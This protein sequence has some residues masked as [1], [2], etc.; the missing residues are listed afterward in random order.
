MNEKRKETTPQWLANVR[1]RKLLEN[2][3]ALIELLGDGKEKLHGEFIFDKRYNFALIEQLI[4][5]SGEMVFDA[6]IMVP[7]KSDRLWGMYNKLS[8]AAEKMFPDSRYSSAQDSEAFDGLPELQMLSDILEWAEG[9]STEISI[10]DLLQQTFDH[11][12]DTRSQRS[13]LSK[14]LDRYPKLALGHDTVHLVDFGG[15]LSRSKSGES[16]DIEEVVCSP[17]RYL[18]KSLSDPSGI[19]IHRVPTEI[20]ATVSDVHLH[21]RNVSSDS[22]LFLDA[23]FMGHS[24]SD[25][26]FFYLSGTANPPDWSEGFRLEKTGNGWMAWTYGTEP[27]DF[28]QKMEHLGRNLFH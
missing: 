28:A 16:L 26:I 27:D 10:M 13:G 8:Q 20:V 9:E 25:F 22:S 15:G 4:E 7:E 18:A 11:V 5:K 3:R 6:S 24:D 19:G 2:A 14:N 12:H 1:R 23:T 17:L 21:L